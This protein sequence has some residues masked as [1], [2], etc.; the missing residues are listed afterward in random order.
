MTKVLAVLGAT[1]QQGSGV[2]DYVIQDSELSKQWQVR[3]ITRNVESEKAKAL[4]KKVEV[5][6]GDATDPVSLAKS[7][8][9]V[10][11][12]FAMTTPVFA[13]D[14]PLTAEFEVIK[15]IGDVA[16]QQGVQYLIFST[17][18]SCRDIS[19][20]RY[21]SVAPFDAKAKGAEYIKTL[22]I[23]SSFYCP[24][25]FMENFAAQPFLAPQKDPSRE[26]TWVFIRNMDPDT[27]M[28]LIDAVGDGGKWIGA[29]LAE[30]DKY[31]G[32][33]ICAATKMY[34]LNEQAA[35]LSNSTGKTVVYKQ[36]SDV[37]F[38]RSLPD[39]VSA[40]FVDYFGFI[41]DYGYYGPG[42]EEKVDWAAKQAR[43]KLSTFEEYLERH[44]YKLE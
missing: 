9:G 30:P 4:Q 39:M 8:E 32:E 42:T 34:S 27:K 37:E 43:G 20:G 1:G 28:P 14:D 18:P 31:E 6:Q 40:L 29:I 7:L 19:N 24:G 13:V 12:L 5:A 11:T 2:V 22:P 41:N 33:T 35:A 10:H 36:V 23:K 21:T 38:A 25:S 26:D 44:P 17:L 15:T 3:A 16:V